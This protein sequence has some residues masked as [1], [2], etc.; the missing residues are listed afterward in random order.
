MLA[1]KA[2]WA[3]FV[4]AS[5]DLAAMKRFVDTRPEGTEAHHI[6]L[7]TLMLEAYIT[8]PAENAPTDERRKFN[9]KLLFSFLGYVKKEEHKASPDEVRTYRGLYDSEATEEWQIVP[10]CDF[11]H[12]FRFFG[13]F[14]NDDTSKIAQLRFHLNLGRRVLN[15]ICSVDLADMSESHLK[16]LIKKDRFVLRYLLSDAARLS[17]AINCAHWLKVEGVALV[18]REQM[19]SFSQLTNA[20]HDYDGHGYDEI[21]F[22][23]ILRI[24]EKLEADAHQQ[25]VM[26]GYKRELVSVQAGM[27]EHPG[28]RLWKTHASATEPQ[29][30]LGGDISLG[31]IEVD[32]TGEEVE[33]AFDVKKV[34]DELQKKLGDISNAGNDF[35]YS[36]GEPYNSEGLTNN[37]GQAD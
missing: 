5:T 9:T 18:P 37:L 28:L 15:L 4:D 16:T 17:A 12:V 27:V 3:D 14:S 11:V 36:N 20:I 29:T 22:S 19:A 7:K 21:Y 32:L 33:N 23:T 6:L 1:D 8:S 35:V 25:A 24:R 2:V 26:E 13:R 10:I 34:E 31:S 30:E